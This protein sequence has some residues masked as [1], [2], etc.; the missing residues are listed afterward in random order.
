[1]DQAITYQVDSLLQVLDFSAIGF[2][3]PLLFFILFSFV[4]FSEKIIYWTAIASLLASFGS[5][6]YFLKPLVHSHQY[7]ILDW[8]TIAQSKFQIT[9]LID[10]TCFWVLAMIHLVTLMVII[11][12]G[13]YMKAELRFE[14]YFAYI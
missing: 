7:Y 9:L 1:M 2:L 13:Y 8:F 11:F 14:K 3:L 12:S 6:F 5:L 4:R 10:E